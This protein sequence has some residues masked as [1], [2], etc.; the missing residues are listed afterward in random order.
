MQEL[1]EICGEFLN[2]ANLHQ[3]LA[4]NLVPRI[5]QLKAQGIAALSRGPGDEYPLSPGYVISRHTPL[6]EWPR[7]P[8]TTGLPPPA[9]RV[10]QSGRALQRSV[11]LT[12]AKAVMAIAP[13]LVLATLAYLPAASLPLPAA[14]NHL[15]ALTIR[16][17]VFATLYLGAALGCRLR[18]LGEGLTT[19]RPLIVAGTD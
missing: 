11:P 14:W 12:L 3:R 10:P 15:T 16:T 7:H 17:L 5:F 18:A 9:R 4:E 6:P 2:W 8:G 19:L 1:T 13:P